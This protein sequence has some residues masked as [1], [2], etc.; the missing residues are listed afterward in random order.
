MRRRAGVG[1]RRERIS[2]KPTLVFE[3]S[4]FFF[5]KLNQKYLKKFCL[6]THALAVRGRLLKSMEIHK[7]F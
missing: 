3:K 6:M 5:V 4:K 1:L 7:S 2:R